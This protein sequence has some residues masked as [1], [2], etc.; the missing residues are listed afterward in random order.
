MAKGK[1][2]GNSEGKYSREE[3]KEKDMEY[4]L[5]AAEENSLTLKVR[6]LSRRDSTGTQIFGN[7]TSD[8]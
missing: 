1:Y 8:S 4:N 2:T 7:Q 6:R 3:M 5:K